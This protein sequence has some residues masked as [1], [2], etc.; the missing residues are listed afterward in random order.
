VG[1]EEKERRDIE[2]ETGIK[3]E[4]RDRRSCDE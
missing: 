1:K 2:E 4:Q 3:K